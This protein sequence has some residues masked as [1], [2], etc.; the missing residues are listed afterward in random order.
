[1]ILTKYYSG[2]QINN[3]ETGG[4]YGRFWGREEVSKWFWLG[5]LREREHLEDLAID[6]R[7]ILK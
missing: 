5:N 4:E 1:V 3:N 2:D 7:K 6:G